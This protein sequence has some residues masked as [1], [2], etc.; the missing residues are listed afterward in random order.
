[1]GIASVPSSGGRKAPGEDREGLTSGSESKVDDAEEE[2]AEDEEI[3][4]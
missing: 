3:S 4:S 2:D 1:M